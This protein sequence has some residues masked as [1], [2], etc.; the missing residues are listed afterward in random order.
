LS[1][2]GC[3]IRERLVTKPLTYKEKLD[4]DFDNFNLDIE[5]ETEKEMTRIREEINSLKNKANKASDRILGTS[6]Q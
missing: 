1:S 5:R 6:P 3:K 4:K 2:L